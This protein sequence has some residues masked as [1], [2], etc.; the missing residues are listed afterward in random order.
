MPETPRETEFTKERYI[1]VN[2]CGGPLCIAE[3]L[4]NLVK[5][6]SFVSET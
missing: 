4:K 5:G 6:T 3:V 1:F 2:G